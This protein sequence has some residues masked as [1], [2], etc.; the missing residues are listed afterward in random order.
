MVTGV[1]VGR[2]L[3]EASNTA[4]FREFFPCLCQITKHKPRTQRVRVYACGHWLLVG[5]GGAAGNRGG[6]GG[7]NLCSFYR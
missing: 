1:K 2:L 3:S 7:E 4:H 5:V 6:G